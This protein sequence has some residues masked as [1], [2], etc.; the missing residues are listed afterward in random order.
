MALAA[1]LLRSNN[2]GDEL[3]VWV[4]S[5]SENAKFYPTCQEV[6]KSH[7]ADWVLVTSTYPA[8]Q[9]HRPTLLPGAFYGR[10]DNAPPMSDL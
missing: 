8:P 4:C 9:K 7:D 3:H 6:E 5:R 1:L 2:I 10:A